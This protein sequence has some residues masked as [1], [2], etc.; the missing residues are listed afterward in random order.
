MAEKAQVEEEKDMAAE[1]AT[2][3]EAEAAETSR[4]LSME[5]ARAAEL[6]RERGELNEVTRR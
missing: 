4:R 3:L 2:R 5:V 6:A 1:E